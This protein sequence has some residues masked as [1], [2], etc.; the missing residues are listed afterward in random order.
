MIYNDREFAMA[1]RLILQQVSIPDIEK[2]IQVANI[3][4]IMQVSMKDYLRLFE[5][6]LNWKKKTNVYRFF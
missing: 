4:I 5:N 3:A 2:A 1:L 6:I